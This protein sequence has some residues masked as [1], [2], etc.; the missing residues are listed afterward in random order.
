MSEAI[1]NIF[2]SAFLITALSLICFPF[3]SLSSCFSSSS[4]HVLFSPLHPLSLCFSLT[5]T[6]LYL[7]H[8][9]AI[10]SHPPRVCES[11]RRL[12]GNFSCSYTSWVSCREHLWVW[13][14]PLRT[15]KIVDCVQGLY[16]F[17]NSWTLFLNLWLL[18]TLEFLGCHKKQPVLPPFIYC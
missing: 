14:Y 16:M 17:L 13:T 12:L 6:S 4:Q 3:F 9:L 8:V 5:T 18:R 11:H 1:W 10:S 7:L 2:N 15:Q